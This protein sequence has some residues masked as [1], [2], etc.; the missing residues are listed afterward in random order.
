[1]LNKIKQYYWD[2]FWNLSKLDQQD[3][4]F[5]YVLQFNLIYFFKLYQTDPLDIKNKNTRAFSNCPKVE[6][7]FQYLFCV[8]FKH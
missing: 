6:H 8:A 3:L 2:L 4:I 7:S 1:M 5:N